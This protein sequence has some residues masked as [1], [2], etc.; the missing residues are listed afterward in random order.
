MSPSLGLRLVSGLLRVLVWLNIACVLLFAGLLLGSLFAE[1]HVV[2]GLARRYP[3]DR[4]GDVMIAVRLT[5][6]IALGVVPLVHLLLTRLRAIVASVAEGDPFVAP[7]ADRLTLIAWALLGI[8]ICDLGFGV[9]SMTIAHDIS[10][11]E[12]S[13]SVTAWLAVALLFVLAGVFR[14]GTRM[15]DELS[16]VV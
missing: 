11:F 14:Q 15:R 7:N 2:R 13:I 9:L 6:L 16:E 4:I 12:W 5:F 1:A 10:G 3:P 8:Q